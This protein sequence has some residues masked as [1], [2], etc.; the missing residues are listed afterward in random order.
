[1]KSNPSADI[2][3]LGGG[4]AGVMAA[5]RL[6]HR[7]RRLKRT[8]TLINGSDQFVERCRL[9]EVATGTQLKRRSLAHMLRGSG[10]Q[11]RQGWVTALDAAN[12][13]VTVRTAQG[14]ATL[15]YHYLI[16]ALGSRVSDADVP[17]VAEYAYTLDPSG[18]RAADALREKLS[19]FGKRPFWAIVVGGGATGIET[20]AQLKAVYPHCT[21]QLVTQGRFG[22]FKN[23]QIREHFVAA[24]AEQQIAVREQARV[25]RVEADQVVLATETLTTD[26]VVWSGGFAAAALAQAAGLPVNHRNQM[27]VDPYLRSISAPE[28][29]GVGDAAQPV[30]QPGAPYRMSLFTAL[31]SGAQAAENIAATMQR[32]EQQPLSFVWYGQG[33]ALGPNDAVG[34]GTYPNDQASGPIF[35]HK[36]AVRIR[37]FFVGFLVTVLELERRFPG[38]F[39]WGGKGRYAQQK[40]L[41]ARQSPETLR[42]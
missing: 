39:Y 19:S 32:K 13:Q 42:A 27:L 38:F 23:E 15:S 2:L 29:Y 25:L 31:V 6:A 1:M 36:L 17:G 41:A 22:A 40:A 4:Y 37:N 30:E 8:I 3:I 35:R 9:H 5:L 20:A 24:F 34:F 18:V 33:V 28:I 11:L 14:D 12:R 16:N 26:V 21:V 7:T 10:V